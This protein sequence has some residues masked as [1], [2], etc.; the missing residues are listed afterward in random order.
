[1]NKESKLNLNASDY[2][3][4]HCDSNKTYNG[5]EVHKMLYDSYIAG[6]ND[7]LDD[8]DEE[9]R[10]A[11]INVF[12]THK[13]YEMFFGVSVKNIHAWLEKQGKKES[14]ETKAKTFLID[15]GYPIDANGIVPT[16]EEMYDII[17]EGLEKQGGQKFFDYENANIQ[18]KDFAPKSAME[19][20]KEEKVDNQN[21]VKPANKVEPKFHEGDWVVQGDNIL[22]IKCVG[23]TCYC[24][25]TVGGYA[26]DILVSEIDSQ[27]HLWT[28]E[29]AKDG[30]VLTSRSPF[31]Y[32]KQ[33]PYGGLNWSN[34]K[35][36]KASNFIF[37]DS[38]V[39]PATK[40]QR[41]LL[42]KKM[43]EAGYE[44]NAEKKKLRKIE[45]NS[46][47]NVQPKFKV[48]DWVVFIATESIYQVEKIENHVYTLKHI[49]AG[50]LRLW[51][52]F[53][54]EKFI[55]EWT[56]QDAKD[57]DVLVTSSE[58]F[59]HNDNGDVLV[60]STGAFIYDGND[61]G[62]SCP[63]SYCD[64]NTLGQ[65]QTGIES[66]WIDKKVYPAT[67]EQR[68]LLF[69]KMKKAGYEWDADKKELSKRVIDEGKSEIDYCFT[70]MMNGEKV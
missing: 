47:N 70:K 18:Q 17:R 60:T 61:G 9:I 11:L 37:T 14:D 65:F 39:H 41:D 49:L 26:D 43:K 10:K 25:E 58:P 31:I 1:M 55:R 48:G 62:G 59:I 3:I 46:D 32:G 44:W 21:C 28:I 6:N 67:K 13:D 36:I 7:T 69:A 35:F 22:K 52:S 38:P 16:Y 23:D 45:Q 57:G 19:A 63:G 27:F 24:F 64:I 5:L 8:K 54:D 33:C 4:S 29:D 50:S 40:E 66:H 20:I 51:L 15:K 30:D 56:I 42:F 53:S 34:N 2:A 68:D 12:A